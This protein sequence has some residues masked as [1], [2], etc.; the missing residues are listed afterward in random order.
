MP[1]VPAWIGQEPHREYVPVSHTPTRQP[2]TRP[3]LPSRREPEYTPVSI[4]GEVQTE[5]PLP[6]SSGPR[7]ESIRHHTPAQPNT[8]SQKPGQTIR[9]IRH[10]DANNWDNSHEP[11]TSQPTN[12]RPTSSSTVPLD[13]FERVGRVGRQ[14]RYEVRK[15]FVNSV[16]DVVL[17][18]HVEGRAY[19][20]LSRDMKRWYEFF[21][22]SVPMK[23]EKPFNANTTYEQHV[24]AYQR[25][26]EWI[27]RYEQ[28]SATRPLGHRAP[29]DL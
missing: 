18:R 28:R 3:F 17:W 22:F 1:E 12:S 21:Y 5:T 16:R 20:N 27:R 7:S 11:T 13:P 15:N 4:V 19:P 24:E 25:G 29:A 14:R 2:R 6:Y 10:P 9:T 26:R 23:G 8:N